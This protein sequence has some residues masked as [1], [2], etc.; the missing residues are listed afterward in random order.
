MWQEKLHE[1]GRRIERTHLSETCCVLIPQ[2]DVIDCLHP[3]HFAV[4]V[5][6]W[7]VVYDFIIHEA[8]TRQTRLYIIKEP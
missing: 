5:T 7:S 1:H 8:D 3:R 2:S 4:V 6:F